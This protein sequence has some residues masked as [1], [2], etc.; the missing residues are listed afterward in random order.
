MA[1]ESIVFI[2]LPIKINQNFALL[3]N[4]LLCPASRLAEQQKY[5]GTS[6]K[7]SSFVI[8][9]KMGVDFIIKEFSVCALNGL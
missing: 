4:F 5:R 7:A 1:I 9:V 3:V 2:N 6:Q 8:G